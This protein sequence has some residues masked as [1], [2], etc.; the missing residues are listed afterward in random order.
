M[1]SDVILTLIINQIAYVSIMLIQSIKSS[2]CSKFLCG[3]CLEV[4]DLTHEKSTQDNQE[5]V[6]NVGATAVS[7][8]IQPLEMK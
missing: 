8:S 3:S 7:G 5:Q 1:V 6:S 4:D 2:N